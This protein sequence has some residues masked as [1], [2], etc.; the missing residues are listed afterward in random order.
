MTTADPVHLVPPRLR[1]L[2][3]RSLNRV[4]LDVSRNPYAYRLGAVLGAHRITTVVDIGANEGQFARG[5]RTNGFGGDIVSVE[6]LADAFAAL[7]RHAAADPRWRVVR[8]AVSDRPGTVTVNVAANSYSSSVLPMAEAHLAA[9]PQSGY[10]GAEEVD[11]LTLDALVDEHGLD[12]ARTA[13]KIDV[14]GYETAVLDGAERTLAGAA[15]VQCEMSLVELYEG[16]RLMPQIVDRLTAA[17]LTLWLLEPGF[18]DP[19]NGRLL[20]CDG[21]FVRA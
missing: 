19:A 9:D 3:K 5:L 14:Q 7:Q 2:A 12:P 15:V 13:F 1:S 6:P 8:A 18:S 11:A 17:G 4:G 21:V 20:Q 10:R 16:Q